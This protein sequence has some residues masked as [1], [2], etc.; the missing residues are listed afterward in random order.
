MVLAFICTVFQLVVSVA[1]ISNRRSFS[2]AQRER[3]QHGRRQAPL[4]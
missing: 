2:G 3:A 4:P 1:L